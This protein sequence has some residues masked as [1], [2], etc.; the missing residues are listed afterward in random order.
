MSKTSVKPHPGSPKN[1]ALA[2]CQ[3]SGM[4]KG[5]GTKPTRS[6]SSKDDH[7]GGSKRGSGSKTEKKKRWGIM[8]FLFLNV[9]KATPGK[10]KVSSGIIF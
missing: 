7:L 1:P 3:G 10:I 8:P 5:R 6:W 9:K 2:F 4:R